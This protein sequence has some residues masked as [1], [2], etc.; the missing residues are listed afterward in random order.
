MDIGLME[1]ERDKLVSI[2]E[3]KKK[4]YNSIREQKDKELELKKE[5][6]VL[7]R[8]IEM[9]QLQINNKSKFSLSL[10]IKKNIPFIKNNI[11]GIIF[12]IGFFMMLFQGYFLEAIACI[13]FGVIGTIYGKTKSIQHN[14]RQN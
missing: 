2:L 13:I 4:E 8:S 7:R 10:F 12:F 5:L 3:Q 11:I 6:S 9:K 14:K 1:K